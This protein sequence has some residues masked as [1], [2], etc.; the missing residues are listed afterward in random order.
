MDLK[1]FSKI[2]Q[3]GILFALVC[4][5]MLTACKPNPSDIVYGQDA[6]SF[7]VMGIVDKQYG[8]EI[9]T[10]KGKVHK[11]D[12]IECMLHDLKNFEPGSIALQLVNTYDTPITLQDASARTYLISEKL[13]SPMGA[14]L[15]AF[16][17]KLSASEAHQEK[18]GTLYDWDGIKLHFET[19]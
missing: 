17:S 8:A 18:G 12:A 2:R 9:V 14:Y 13:P 10:K 5:S 3:P 1:L 6:C 15:T 19:R 11:Y 4:I 7:C 16:D